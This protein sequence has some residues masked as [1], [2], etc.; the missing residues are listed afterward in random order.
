MEE[1]YLAG[2]AIYGDDFDINQIQQWYDEETEAYA[3]LGSKEAEEYVYGYH[4][5]NTLHGFNF[6]KDKKFENVLGL[7]A[8][9]GHEFYPIIDRISN[10]HIV[11]P[12]DNLRS[13]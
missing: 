6:L 13:A 4:A 12:S 3:N 1:K 8:A 2:E 10:L 11:E 5:L 9:W 7:G